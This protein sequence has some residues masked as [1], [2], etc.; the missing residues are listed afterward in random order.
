MPDIAATTA[1]VPPSEPV[2]TTAPASGWGTALLQVGDQSMSICAL[3]MCFVLR[4]GNTPC[5]CSQ[6]A[7]AQLTG[8]V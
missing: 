6:R 5:L 1:A 3:S 8:L 2:S 7:V 4:S